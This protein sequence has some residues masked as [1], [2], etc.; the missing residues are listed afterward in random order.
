MAL[1]HNKHQKINTS[2]DIYHKNATAKKPRTGRNSSC[3]P[4]HV[5]SE[6]IFYFHFK[7]T[8]KQNVADRRQY[9]DLAQVSKNC[10]RNPSM[11][12]H[13]SAKTMT[14][15]NPVPLP[16]A[17]GVQFG[18]CMRAKKK[19]NKIKDLH[20]INSLLPLSGMQI[21]FG[22]FIIWCALAV[23]FENPMVR[24]ARQSYHRRNR[25]GVGTYI[26]QFLSPCMILNVLLYKGVF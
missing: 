6:N 23:S 5:K 16:N 24:I 12:T 22:C 19:Q 20:L 9:P 15:P 14:K 8:C 21:L 13:C 2:P 10:R 26:S 7:Q 11:W 18:V 25:K 4:P 3:A 1:T 17:S